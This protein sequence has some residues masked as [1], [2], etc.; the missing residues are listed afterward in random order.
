MSLALAPK[1]EESRK[2]Y[3]RSL[4]DFT[5]ELAV[6][7][8]GGLLYFLNSPLIKSNSPTNYT[9]LSLKV[10]NMDD[11][12]WLGMSTYESLQI[13]SAHE[14]PSIYKWSNNSAKV[15]PSIYSLLNRCS[16]VLGSMYL[17]KILAQPTKNINILKYRHELIE[18]CLQ[19]CNKSIILSL[20]DC[21][22]HCHCVLVST[23]TYTLFQVL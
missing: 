3:I 8:L 14:H 2:R 13:F 4:V 11:L 18:F 20:I 16:S 7:A 23:Y 15:G 5:Q 12:V 1:N 22:K 9:I 17:K 19:P 10:I 6:C 21:I